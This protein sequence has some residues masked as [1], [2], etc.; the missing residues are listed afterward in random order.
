MTTLT[1]KQ[2][3]QAQLLTLRGMLKLEMRGM[4]RSRSPSA[5][6]MLKQL[7]YKGSREVVLAQLDKERQEILTGVM[8]PEV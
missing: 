4:K 8:L 2:I 6:S 1:G 7:G 3:E 5:Y